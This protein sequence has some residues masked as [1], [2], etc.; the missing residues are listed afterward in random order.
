MFEIGNSLREARLRQG[1]DFPRVEAD[2][3]V[4]GKYLQAL[5]AERFEVLP[6]ETYVKG[7]LRTYAEYLGL[8]GQLY[9]DEFNSRYASAEEPLVAASPPRRSRSRASESS[10][11]VVAL[12]GIVAVTLLVV[13]AF[14]FNGPG[15][16]PAAEL[17]KDPTTTKSAPAAS[18]DTAPIGSASPTQPKLARL[19]L[20]A[21]RG[22]CWV[23]VHKNSATGELVYSGT[24]EEGQTQ[25]F[26]A[27]RLWITLGNASALDAKLNGKRV[28]DFP[29]AETVVV[30][31][32]GVRPQ[33]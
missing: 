9:V 19:V 15:T 33:A 17:G 28:V 18:T 27:R 8:D 22:D 29:I 20:T 23:Q 7:F 3:K 13:V 16:D 21:A 24:M 12:A 1:L 32:E 26:V 14:A 30:T 4:R 2:T 31:S 11:V 10:F 25:R 6:A 5:E